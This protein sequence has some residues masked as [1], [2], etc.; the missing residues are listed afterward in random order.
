MPPASKEPNP[1]SHTPADGPAA[2]RL[3]LLPGVLPDPETDPVSPCHRLSIIWREAWSQKNWPPAA[4]ARLLGS[5]VLL[6][7]CSWLGIVLSHQSEG[8][9][10]IWL[11]NGILFGLL[12]T[13]PRQRWIAYFVA[14]LT[15]DI[16]ADTLW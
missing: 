7:T 3:H 11:P 1:H 8:V 2:A 16:L 14:G 15:G 5:L 9:A 13:Q 6:T 12:I 4:I 10:T